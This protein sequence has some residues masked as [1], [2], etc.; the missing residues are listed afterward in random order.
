MMKL[1]EQLES[2]KAE[3][4]R[5]ER[6]AAAATCAEVGHRWESLGGANCGCKAG[7][8]SVP[9]NTC[10]ACGDCDYGDNDDASEIRRACRRLRADGD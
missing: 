9:V 8:C 1:A 2:A 6:A 4:A 7:A 5:L 3:V 10:T